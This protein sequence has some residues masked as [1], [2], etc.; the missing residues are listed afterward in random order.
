MPEGGKATLAQ[1]PQTRVNRLRIETHSRVEVKDVTDLIRKRIMQ[2]Q[3]ES[4]VCHVFV[5]HTSDAVLI[6]EN[7]DPALRKALDAFL[8]KLAPREVNYQHNDRNCD[9]HLTAALLGRST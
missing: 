3:V 7:D 2:P 4:G 1:K 6:Q 8:Q 5:P 9:S